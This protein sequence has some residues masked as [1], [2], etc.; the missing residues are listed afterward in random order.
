M[1]IE[2]TALALVATGAVLLG[3]Q[4]AEASPGPGPFSNPGWTALNT[5]QIENQYMFV[6]PWDNCASDGLDSN[7][8][9]EFLSLLGVEGGAL[10]PWA[11]NGILPYWDGIAIFCSLTGVH[12]TGTQGPFFNA[13]NQGFVQI[14]C[15]PSNL[16][17]L[18]A[19]NPANGLAGLFGV[20]VGVP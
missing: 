8:A 1:K 20:S 15:D 16:S 7:C 13:Q 11:D 6:P 12:E 5:T 19:N 10:H 4:P 3:G 2:M 18:I 9:V 14:Q 17:D